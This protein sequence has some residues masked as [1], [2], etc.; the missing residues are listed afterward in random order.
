MCACVRARVFSFELVR[1]TYYFLND[2]CS[3][4]LKTRAHA[5]CGL[6]TLHYA[7]SPFHCTIRDFGNGWTSS[8]REPAGRRAPIC[9]RGQFVRPVFAHLC[10]EGGFVRGRYRILLV[11]WANVRLLYPTPASDASAGW[12][13]A[14]VRNTRVI[15]HRL[16]R[17]PVAV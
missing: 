17:A 16:V 15:W 8:T 13:G 7:R 9:G 12:S 14:R 2:S 4:S 1:I 11:G 6:H 5:Y 10:T 3:T